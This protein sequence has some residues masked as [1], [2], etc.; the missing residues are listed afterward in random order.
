M[1]DGYS[2]MRIVELPPASSA[3]SSESKAVV[4]DFELLIAADAEKDFEFV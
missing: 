2:A 4:D 1:T 3:L